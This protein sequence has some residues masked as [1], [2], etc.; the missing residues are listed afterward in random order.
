VGGNKDLLNAK[1]HGKRGFR[2]SRGGSAGFLF[3]K[4][5]KKYARQKPE[6]VVPT[7]NRV[8]GEGASWTQRNGKT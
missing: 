4:K 1:T 5:R 2:S 3:R 6:G 7:Y 8:K